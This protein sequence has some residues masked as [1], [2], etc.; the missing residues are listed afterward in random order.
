MFNPDLR[1]WALL[2]ITCAIECVQI[3]INKH[4]L[5]IIQAYY[6]LKKKLF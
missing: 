4:C 1:V 6:Y 2:D 3:K 5:I